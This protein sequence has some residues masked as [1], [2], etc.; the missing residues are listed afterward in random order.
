MNGD[1]VCSWRDSLAADN[2]TRVLVIFDQLGLEARRG[3]AVNPRLR[4]RL[5]AVDMRCV[6]VHLRELGHEGMPGRE[7]ANGI[8]RARVA[9]YRQGLA[10][11]AAEIRESTGARL[12]HPVSPAE[13]IEGRP[14]RSTVNFDASADQVVRWAR[15]SSR[16]KRLAYSLA[17]LVS[18]HR[19]R[20][21]Q[22]RSGQRIAVRFAKQRLSLC[23]RMDCK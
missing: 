19:L 10:A 20:P 18:K 9:G 17:L 23:R 16:P 7:M 6:G 12:L 11:A 15:A 1:A 3:G 21:G 14:S 4:P 13:R 22:T 2:C 8:G 5:R